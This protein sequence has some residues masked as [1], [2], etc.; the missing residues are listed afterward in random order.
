M[1]DRLIDLLNTLLPGDGADWPAAG[2]QAMAA[3]V[4]ELAE[5][6]PGACDALTAIVDAL[7]PQF[8]TLPQTQREDIVRGIET[9]NTDQFDAV[10]TAAYNAYYTDPAIRDVVER[11]TG[12]ENRPP[13]PLGYELEPFD[14]RLLDAVKARGAIWRR[15]D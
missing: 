3:R 9:D 14:E 2:S 5:G 8:G 4:I 13:Q 6:V 12:Y 10:V 11:L 7:P 15:V 1:T